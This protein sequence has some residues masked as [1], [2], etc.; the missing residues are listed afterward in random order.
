LDFLSLFYIATKVEKYLRKRD[1]L[2]SC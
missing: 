2:F 1:L